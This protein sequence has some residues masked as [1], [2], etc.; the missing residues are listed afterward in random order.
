M[1]WDVVKPIC[2]GWRV[3]WRTGERFV[4]MLPNQF[5]RIVSISRQGFDE[6]WAEINLAAS[7][8]RETFA[9]RGIQRF[10][11]KRSDLRYAFCVEIANHLT[12]G[13]VVPAKWEDTLYATHVPFV[14]HKPEGSA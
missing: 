5:G 14:S 2:G 13:C 9:E 6:C 11:S 7:I 4:S 10:G 12:A 3:E 8:A 1:S